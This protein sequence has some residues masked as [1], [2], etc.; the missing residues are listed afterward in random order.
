MIDQYFE[1]SDEIRF[2]PIK[3]GRE[4]YFV[5][6]YPPAPKER[7][8]T[9]GL[10]FLDELELEGVANAMEDEFFQ[11]IQRYPLPV[12]VSAFDQN[13]DL[14]NLE[15]VKG[16]S[17][18]IGYP[19]SDGSIIKQW[20]LIKDEDLP[21]KALDKNHLITV[22]Q[23][24]PFTKQSEIKKDWEK[25]AK[26]VRTGWYIVFVW[27]VIVPA[28]IAWLG[29]ASPLVSWMAMLYAWFQAYVK[30]MKLAGKWPKTQH[31]KDDERERVE[32]EHHHYH[33]KENPEG[34][35]RLKVEN[36]EK[37]EREKIQKDFDKLRGNKE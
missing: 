11:W 36:L 23:D 28:F 35:L 9:L 31:E 26:R 6:Y 34:F 32:M 13:G 24:V 4:L 27:A 29:W 5:E 33:C 2:E 15:G 14:Y 25:R 10:T 20:K 19:A 8:A 30:G 21:D 3:E 1:Q 12:M 17:H 7:F 37:W 22:Y 18:I 16:F